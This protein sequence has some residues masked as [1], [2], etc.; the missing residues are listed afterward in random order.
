[1]LSSR[2]CILHYARTVGEKDLFRGFFQNANSNI[3][4][5]R[6]RTMLSKKEL[7]E[8]PVDSTDIYKCNIKP[9]TKLGLMKIFLIN[10]V[11][12]RSS[13]DISWNKSK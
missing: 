1:M 9:D 12:H 5:K 8:L 6:V 13:G 4:E 11:M 3:L 7:S 2:N 10:F